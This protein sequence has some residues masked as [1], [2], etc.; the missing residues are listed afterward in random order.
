[1]KLHIPCIS[2]I[3]LCTTS[4]AFASCSVFVNIHASDGQIANVCFYSVATLVGLAVFG[5]DVGSL[6]LGLA[7]VLVGF[8]FMIGSASSKYIEVRLSDSCATT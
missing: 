4:H 2:L 3:F 7:G 6:V 1:M 8:A 5:V